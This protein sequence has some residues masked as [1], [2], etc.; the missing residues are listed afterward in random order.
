M[1]HAYWARRWR[2]FSGV[3]EAARLV[4]C[5]FMTLM[6]Q[7]TSNQDRVRLAHSDN[8]HVTWSR[9]FGRPSNLVQALSLCG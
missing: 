5:P 3:L 1:Q 7:T 9:P 4:D 8:V 6:V 2:L